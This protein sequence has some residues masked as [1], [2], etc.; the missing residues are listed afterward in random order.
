[1]FDV[2]NKWAKERY[3]SQ[4]TSSFNFLWYTC[5]Q[6]IT[7]HNSTVKINNYLFI[8]SSQNPKINYL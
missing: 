5:G 4:L 6:K 2:N 3:R 8:F 7:Y 1:M